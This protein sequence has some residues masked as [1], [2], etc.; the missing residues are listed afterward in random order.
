MDRLDAMLEEGLKEFILSK[1]HPDHEVD[2]EMVKAVWAPRWA[3]IEKLYAEAEAAVR[4]PAQRKRLE[5]FGD[6]LVLAHY[7]LRSAQLATEPLK[8]R[9]Y[10]SDQEL[11]D[12]L[13]SRKGTL[14][15]YDWGTATFAR[16]ERPVLTPG[17]KP[18]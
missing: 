9:F 10:R 6:N 3:E 14:S 16:R 7:N 11:K 4:T 2:Y 18:D 1:R 17:W 5:M 12:F 13:V 8:S 15:L